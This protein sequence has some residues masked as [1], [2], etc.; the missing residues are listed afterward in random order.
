MFRSN[1]RTEFVTELNKRQPDFNALFNRWK[2]ANAYD[3]LGVSAECQSS[4]LK[5]LHENFQ[6]VMRTLLQQLSNDQLTQ[7]NHVARLIDASFNHLIA[8]SNQ[9]HLAIPKERYFAF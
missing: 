4:D 5:R 9:Y 2:S 1:L 6:F 8:I 7:A 3:I